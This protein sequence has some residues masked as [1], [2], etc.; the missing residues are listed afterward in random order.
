MAVLITYGASIVISSA[1]TAVNDY[2]VLQW[3]REGRFK[4]TC[5]ASMPA[6]ALIVNVVATLMH[7]FLAI[8]PVEHILGEGLNTTLA[9]KVASNELTFEPGQWV[10]LGVIVLFIMVSQA[11]RYMLS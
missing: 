6:L 2:R 8:T 9:T 7:T 10:L 4:P 5:L 1:V 3:V 11:P